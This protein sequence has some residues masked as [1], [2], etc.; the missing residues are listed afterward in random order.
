MLGNWV[1]LDEI[2]EVPIQNNANVVCITETWL[3]TQV[4]DYI[5]IIAMSGYNVFRKDR[6]HAAGRGVCTYIHESAIPC[7]KTCRQH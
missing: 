4:P 6:T 5:I 2:R 3:T 7:K 1:K